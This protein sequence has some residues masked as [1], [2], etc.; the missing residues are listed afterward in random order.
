MQGMQRTYLSMTISLY[1]IFLICFISFLAT[2]FGD[3]VYSPYYIDF[4]LNGYGNWFF[5][6]FYIIFIDE[7]L[8]LV[9]KETPTLNFTNH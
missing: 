4:F 1:I 6:L 2:F 3:S 5:G 9:I 7:I 8:L